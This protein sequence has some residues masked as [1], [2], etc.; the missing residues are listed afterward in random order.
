MI[1]RNLVLT[2]LLLV[3]LLNLGDAADV[4][5]RAPTGQLEIDD[6]L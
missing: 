2:A 6:R 4:H 5:M 1:M 3:S